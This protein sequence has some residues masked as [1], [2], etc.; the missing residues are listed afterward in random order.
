M[1]P[2][3]STRN[4]ITASIALLEMSLPQE[5]PIDWIETASMG[6]WAIVASSSLTLATNFALLVIADDAST[7]MLILPVWRLVSVTIVDWSSNGLILPRSARTV[8]TDA[9]DGTSQTV[10]PLKSMLKFSPLTNKC[11]QPDGYDGAGQREPVAPTVYEVVMGLPSVEPR[12]RAAADRPVEGAARGMLRCRGHWLSMFIGLVHR[13]PGH[14]S[15]S[16]T[17]PRRP[18]TSGRSRPRAG[19]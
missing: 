4:T 18:K 13:H 12:E 1:H 16:G 17:Q 10:P 9:V 6:A 5:G 2:E 8:A 19:V 15:R 14:G 3:M 11:D 7:S